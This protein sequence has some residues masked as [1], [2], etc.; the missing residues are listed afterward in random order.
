M[1]SRYLVVADKLVLRFPIKKIVIR[2]NGS[3]VP[4]LGHL[5][6]R[7]MLRLCDLLSTLTGIR[8]VPVRT[9][10]RALGGQDRQTD[11]VYRLFEARTDGAMT[12]L[13]FVETGVVTGDG[14]RV[15][16]WVRR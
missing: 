2:K 5:V 14:R 12:A 8:T 15:W 7:Q 16:R 13:L 1:L 3:R 6:L 11:Q 10:R 4:K 9:L